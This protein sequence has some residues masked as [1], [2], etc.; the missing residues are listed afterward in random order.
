MFIEASARR[1]CRIAQKLSCLR[2]SDGIAFLD[3]PR[4]RH[5]LQLQNF[6]PD[7]RSSE[8]F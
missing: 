7:F 6:F 4:V 1:Q 8:H 2:H 3:G 5:N